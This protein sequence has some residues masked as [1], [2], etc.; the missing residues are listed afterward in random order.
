M[1]LHVICDIIMTA[2]FLA[3]KCCFY[4]FINFLF[5]EEG[6]TPPQL[7]YLFIIVKTED[8]PIALLWC[9]LILLK[10]E[11]LESSPKYFP[12]YRCKLLLVVY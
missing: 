8:V 5:W 9:P 3:K 12:F 4:F 7:Y 1:S 11:K 10:T 2:Y 6:T